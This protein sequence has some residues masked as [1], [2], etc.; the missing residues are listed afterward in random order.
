MSP[1][2][3][4]IA[5]ALV[6]LA[7]AAYALAPTAHP[8]RPQA[9]AG[10][11]RRAR[12]PRHRW[13][14][15]PPRSATSRSYLDG[16][17][18]VTPLATVTVKSRVD[19]QLMAVHFPRRASIVAAGDS[20]GRDRSAPVSGAAR[21]GA[22]GRWR[23]TRRCSPTRKVDLQRY[24]KLV[25]EDSIPKQQLDTQEA[26]VQQYEGT[27]AD[28]SGADRQRQAAARLQPHH[29]ADQRAARPAPGR[30]RQ[31]GARQRC[32]R[33]WWSSRSC[34]R[35]PSSSPFPKTACRRCCA[36]LQRGRAV[37]RS[38]PTTA[39]SKHQL[40]TGN[41]ADGRQSDRSDHRHRCGS[42][43]SFPTTDDA[44]F[45]NQFVN[46]RLELDVQRDATLVPAAAVQRGTQGTFVYVVKP[47]QTVEVRPVKV[48]VT[49]GDLVSDRP[50][51]S[52]PASSWWSTAPTACAPAAR[53]TLQARDAAQPATGRRMNLSR[54]FIVRPVATTLADGGD[55]ARRRAWR[56]ASCRSRR[57]RRSTIRPSRSSRSIPAPAPT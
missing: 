49:E 14:P 29:R 55:P 52:R 26:L 37:D 2:A 8:P 50:A 3:G 57:C 17:G 24:R 53:S 25:A 20:A 42:R 33:A 27:V 34:S 32:R 47:D 10:A 1:L 9:A 18:T 51:A 28:R 45:P 43:R 44:L 30:S 56:I 13:W 39:S 11:M 21:A 54:P 23:A 22:R 16:I 6:L 19:G 36:R 40:A 41:A 48:G 4:W 38:R 15:S 7:G 46:A 35:S 5:P 31:H 12:A